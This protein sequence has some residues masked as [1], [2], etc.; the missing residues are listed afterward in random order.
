MLIPIF[1]YLFIQDIWRGASSGLPLLRLLLPAHHQRLR[2]G[3]PHRKNPISLTQTKKILF[4]KKISQVVDIACYSSPAMLRCM[5]IRELQR[6]QSNPDYARLFQGRPRRFVLPLRPPERHEGQVGEIYLDFDN[7]KLVK[8]PKKYEG[9]KLL[10]WIL[11][12]C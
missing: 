3:E 10:L 5:D 1:I 9:Y 12:I 8:W 11:S 6:A 2:G 7:N 4:F